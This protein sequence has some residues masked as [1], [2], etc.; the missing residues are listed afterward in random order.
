MEIE[1]MGF[2]KLEQTVIDMITESL[3]KLGYADAPIQLYF[4]LSSLNHL[5]EKEWNVA[6][7][8]GYLTAFEEAVGVRLGEIEHG[9]KE[10]RFSLRVPTRGVLYVKEHV[11]ISPFLEELVKLTAGYECTMAEIRKLFEKYSDQ[12]VESDMQDGEFDCVLYFADGKPDDYRYCFH[13]EGERF[14]YHRFGKADYEAL[15]V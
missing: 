6:E 3:I 12:V 11:E 2:H 10:D 13:K 7:M 5:L 1:T 9:V 15:G 8:E 14:I 4:P